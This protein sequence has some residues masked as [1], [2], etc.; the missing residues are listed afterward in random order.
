M[1]NGDYGQMYDNGRSSIFV[2]GT[3]IK[4][5]VKFAYI[6]GTQF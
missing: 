4:I 3:I 2:A 5:T 6:M 1:D